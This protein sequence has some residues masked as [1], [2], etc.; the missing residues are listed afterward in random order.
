MSDFDL[1][2]L[3]QDAEVSANRGNYLKS[4]DL[5]LQATKFDHNC[6]TAW[7][8]LGVTNAKLGN[9]EESIN[10]FE[11]AHRINPDYGPTN[12]NLALILE[13]RDPERASNFAKM[14][15]ETSS[16][17]SELVRISRLSKVKKIEIDHITETMTC[18]TSTKGTASNN[19]DNNRLHEE[20]VTL[21]GI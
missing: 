18:A 3:L 21:K 5:Y 7:Y 12:A 17:S 11:Q 16:E 8:G 14:A 9:L 13:H 10:S 19:Q 4:T 1:R 15:I 20:I 6:T 2:Q